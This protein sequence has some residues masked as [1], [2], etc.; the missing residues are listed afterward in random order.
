MAMRMLSLLL[1][2]VIGIAGCGTSSPPRANGSALAADGSSLDAVVKRTFTAYGFRLQ[3][4]RVLPETTLAYETYGR[5]AP[6]GRNAI[7]IT[8]GFTSSGHAAGK[9]STADPSPGW[10]D[11]LIGPGKAIDTGRYFVVSS[12]MLGSSYG[13]TGPS[14]VNPATSKPYGPDFPA[15]TVRDIV[16]AQRLLLSA[17]GVNHLVAVAGPS[18]GGIQAFQWAV[19][20]PEFMSGVVPVVSQPRTRGMTSTDELTTRFAKD[21]NWNG[22]WHY[23]RG[24][25][26]PTLTEVRVETL[27]RYGA[28]EMLSVTIPDPAQREA[29]IRQRAEA[30]AREFDPNSMVT[31]RRALETFDTESEFGKIRAKVLYVL[32]R[33]DKLFPPSIAPDVM[34]KLAKAGVDATYVEIDSEF[35]HLASGPE[36]AKWGPAVKAFLDSLER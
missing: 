10:W 6:D 3:S 18:Y 2:L 25:I 34:D 8:H 32:S 20:Y 29:A 1:A 27:M 22:G 13:S 17:L 5:L 4:G 7:L 35:G 28:N 12:N 9:Y 31:L 36:W 19:T 21:P 15:I 16:E 23:D 26:L 24:G 30:W 14:S 11:G 33:T